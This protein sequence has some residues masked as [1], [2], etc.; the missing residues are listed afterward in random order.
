MHNIV[1][2]G[3]KTRGQAIAKIAADIGYKIIAYCSSRKLSQQKQIGNS[4]VISPEEVQSLWNKKEIDAILLGIAN[5][6]HLKD[7]QHMIARDFPRDIRIISFDEIEAI[8][9]EK[10]REHLEY[11]WKIPFIEQSAIW[12]ENFMKEV[13]FW[14]SDVANPKGIC[15][16]DYQKKIENKDFLG[17]D[18]AWKELAE[19]LRSQSIV[20][21]IGCGLTPYF[22]TRLPNGEQIQLIR[23]DPLASFYN[24]I[25]DRCIEGPYSKCQFGLFEFMANFYEE[26]YS[27]AIIISNALDHCIDPYIECDRVPV[28]PES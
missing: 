22:G 5:P 11:R 26:N 14:V 16:D 12:V 28:Y 8:Y 6:K 3:T 25:N 2:W 23:I 21:D 17:I 7:V 13:N 24:R 1:V 9:L 10:E 18:P 15:H 27:D 4:T 20:M 19:S